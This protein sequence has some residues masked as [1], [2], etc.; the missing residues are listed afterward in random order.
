[1]VK[2]SKYFS[3]E[4]ML[5]SQTAIRKN[6]LEQFEPSDA[7]VENLKKLTNKI[8]DPIREKLESPIV[9]SSGYRCKRLN[10]AIG[11][12][13]DSQH[14]EGKAADIKSVKLNTQELFDFILTLNLP[15]DQIIQE[16]DSWVHISFDEKRNRRQVLK[17]IKKNGKT[18]YIK[19]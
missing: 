17:A 4:E 13:I 2:I 14:P 11:G 3:L 19:I 18:Q 5:E 6:I 1:M 7:V 12:A 16:F 8:L 15:F 10:K 9:V